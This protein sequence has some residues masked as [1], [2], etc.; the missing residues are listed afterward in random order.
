MR[1][2]NL[3]NLYFTKDELLDALELWCQH[4]H[5]AFTSHFRRK[6]E[7]DWSFNE[8][9]GNHDLI[10]SFDGEINWVDT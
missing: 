1:E 10:V 6:A 7:V 3:V 4:N 9:T 5:A 8:D 2:T